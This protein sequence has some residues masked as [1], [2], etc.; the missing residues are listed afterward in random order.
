MTTLGNPPAPTVDATQQIRRSVFADRATQTIPVFY[1]LG[2]Y[3]GSDLPMAQ[4]LAD[5][6]AFCERYFASHL[7]PTFPNRMY[8][9]SGDV[10]YDR[11]GEAIIDN[12]NGD[13]LQLSR[14][15]TIFDLLTR[16]RIGWRVYE[17]F[18]SVTMLRM[19]ARYATDD[20]HIVP[21]HGSTVPFER[22][23]QDVDRGNLPAVTMIEPAMHHE[24]EDD[25]HPP[26]D[27][28]RGQL[29][30]KGVYDTLRSNGALWQK[31]LLVITYDEHGGFYDHVVPPIADVRT[32]PMIVSDGGPSGPGPFTSSTLVTH[33]G[34]RVPT[35]VVS[36]WTPAGKGPDIVLDHCSI[37]KT[38]LARFCGDTKPFVSDRVN[39]SR[40]LEAY[41]SAPEPRMNVPPSPAMDPLPFPR[42]PGRHRMI[43]TPPLSRKKMLSGDADFH[44]LTGMVARLLGRQRS[45]PG[46]EVIE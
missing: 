21:L 35:F 33:Y 41:V 28:Y 39:A 24:P 38:I 31:T 37:V 23:Q 14:A 6:Y 1:V 9:L 22:L 8:A 15:M 42:R 19:F 30:L 17:S 45:S 7:G 5:N 27:M 25:D 34:A 18:P 4:F 32:R 3:V 2:Y 16:K 13:N 10:Q 11:A 36:P 46:D 40:T 26:A 44:E 43:E 12:N 29:F 20:V